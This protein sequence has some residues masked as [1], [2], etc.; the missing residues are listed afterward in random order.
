MTE[1]ASGTTPE[2]LYLELMKQ[3]LTRMLWREKYRPIATS[4]NGW[5]RI[6]LRPLQLL[7]RQAQLE[8]VHVEPDRADARQEGRDWP[9]EA[10]TMVGLKR[11]DNLR[12]CVTAVIRNGVPGDLIETGV[13]RGGSSI[14]MRA[15][16]KAYGDTS[17]KVWLAD[18]FRGLPPPDPGRYPVD[19]GDTLWKYAE[20]AIPMEQVKANFSRYGLLDDQ[21]A[22]LPGWFRDTLPT[23]PIERL[24]VLRLDGDLYE[25]T[26]EALVALYPKVSAGGFVI[27]DDYGLPTCRAAIEDFRL[28]QG[29]TDPIQL[30]DWTGAFWQRSTADRGVTTARRDSPSLRVVS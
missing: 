30:I 18:S 5:R 13:W 9:L 11:L 1:P 8:L 28:A 27:V 21:V 10:E 2:E 26:M 14:F 3:C 17:R 4:L 6:V 16:L 12:N 29:I 19:E 24:A 20:L 15:I 25:S 7:V 23:A 22:F